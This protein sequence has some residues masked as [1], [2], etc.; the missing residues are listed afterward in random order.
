MTVSFITFIIII[1]SLIIQIMGYN[2][3]KT[4]KNTIILHIRAIAGQPGQP[5]HRQ[6]HRAEQGGHGGVL[7]QTA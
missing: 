2:L 4:F 3:S 7:A 1:V 5:G 6:Q